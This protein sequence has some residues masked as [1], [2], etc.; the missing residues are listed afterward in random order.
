MFIGLVGLL[1][2]TV[3]L[4]F[5]KEELKQVA[6]HIYVCIFSKKEFLIQESQL[7]WKGSFSK[8]RKGLKVLCPGHFSEAGACEKG[9]NSCQHSIIEC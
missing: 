8:V 5:S 4:I 1:A 6:T 3:L 9:P 2:D 7:A